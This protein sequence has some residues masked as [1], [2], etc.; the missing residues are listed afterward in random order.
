M[1]EKEKKNVGTVL[2]VLQETI[3]NS[4]RDGFRFESTKKAHPW[5]Q[6]AP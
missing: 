2:L 3:A 6:G 4:R 1:T 5:L